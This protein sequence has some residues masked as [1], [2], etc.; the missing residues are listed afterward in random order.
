MAKKK[1]SRKQLLKGPDEF[2]T[3]SS[4]ALD[5]LR[6]NQQKL[7]YVGI[8]IAVV[9]IAYFAIYNWMGIV[10][11]K[12]QNAYNTAAKSILAVSMKPDADPAD[13]KK[14]ADLFEEVIT[15][16]GMSKV[17]QLALSQA[18]YVKYLEKNYSDAII[19]YEKFLDTVSGDLQYASLTRL[20][21][22]ACHEAKGDP[23]KA[24][25]ILKPLVETP[26]DSS[27]REAAMWSLA[28]LY[29]LDNKPEK[30]E[31]ILKEFVKKYQYS[32]YHAMAKAQ[33]L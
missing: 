9:A 5:F 20:A 12:G 11:E 18:A 33:L 14:S 7:R 4:R 26:S 2:L 19:L 8:A 16:Y 28:R 3:F 15:E 24:I 31:T 6:T 1:I 23:H 25:E 10:N 21:L 13:L 29:R 27:F 22:A 17:A 32:P 30:E